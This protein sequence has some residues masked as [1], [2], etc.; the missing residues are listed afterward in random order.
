MRPSDFAVPVA[1]LL[2]AGVAWTSEQSVAPKKPDGPVRIVYWEKWTGFEGDAMRAVVEAFNQK[3]D[4]IFVELLTVSGIQDKT[5]LAIAGGIPPDVAGLYGPNISQYV[6][7][8]A[9]QSLSPMCE[10]AGIRRENYI[11]V[12]WDI[13]NI[14]GTQYALPS[15]P[16]STALHYNTQMFQAVGHD[17]AK[18]PQTIEEMD[19]LADKLVIRDRSGRITRHGFLPSE[20]GWWNWGW[21]FVFGGKL[22]NE[23]DSLTANDP[24]NVKALEWVQ[25]YSKRYGVTDIQAFRQGFGNFSSPQ[26]AFLSEK[27]GMVLQGVWMYNFIDQYNPKLKWKASPFPHPADRPDTA[28]MTFADEDVLVIP[29]GARHP[30][31]AFEFIAF[32]QSQEGMELLCMGQRKH[33]PLAKVSEQFWRNHPNPYIRLF[34]ELPKGKYVVSPPKIAIWPEYQTELIN[35]YDEVQLLRKTPQQALDDVQARMQPKFTEYR[36]RLEARN[37]MEQR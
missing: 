10:A 25:G 7:A 29:R 32:V 2:I 17:P 20:P 21:G 4:R 19:A 12:Y 3:Q 15:A 24:R 26:N 9:I 31:E 5:L 27:V 6:D 16:A 23:K 1:L 13:G 35:A 18:P 14:G 28:K 34:T 37:K 22:W 8:Q 30:K 36:R 33:S 11:P